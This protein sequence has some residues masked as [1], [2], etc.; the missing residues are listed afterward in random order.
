MTT[1]AEVLNINEDKEER[2]DPKIPLLWL[3]VCI[4]LGP[5]TPPGPKVS[6]PAKTQLFGGAGLLFGS[7]FGCL[8]FEHELPPDY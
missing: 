4:D 1:A 8:F 7:R 6:M 5:P 3:L 2:I